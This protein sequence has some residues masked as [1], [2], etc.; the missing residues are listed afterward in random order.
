[1]SPNTRV[2]VFISYSRKDKKWLDKL[3]TALK[4]L[5]RQETI[6]LWADTR[7]QA[8][9][10]WQEEITAALSKAKVAVLLVSHD[11]LASDFIANEEMPFILAVAKAQGLR[12]L[13][14]PV[15]ASL[16]EKTKIA[17]YQAAH[18]PR[19]PLDG[20][21]PATLNQ[22][23]VAIAM[24]I[25]AA[26][27]DSGAPAPIVAGRIHPHVHAADSIPPAAH[28]RLLCDLEQAIDSG[29]LKDSE[30]GPLVLETL[31]AEPELEL[32]DSY[33]PKWITAGVRLG[34]YYHVLIRRSAGQRD[35]QRDFAKVATP[36]LVGVARS[37]ERS[38][39]AQ[40]VVVR[41]CDILAQRLRLKIVWPDDPDELNDVKNALYRA[42]LG[43]AVL[44]SDD[45]LCVLQ[46]LP[47]VGPG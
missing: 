27:G 35:W 24:K 8:G 4:P 32:V 11:F 12:I 7:I 45:V 21:G 25:E 14:I 20:L 3:Q 29:E 36:I 23:L 42:C 47:V 9:E 18:D 39:E 15:T 30:L 5:I 16:V 43:S 31:Q 33:D 28:R 13:W 22:A 19:R 38:V 6:D 37:T 10:R 2:R 41:L 34:D 40:A 26:A 44:E 17:E 1:M 46:D